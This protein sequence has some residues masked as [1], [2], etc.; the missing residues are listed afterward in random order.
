MK[1]H[2]WTV[3]VTYKSNGA[4]THTQIDPKIMMMMIKR[5]RRFWRAYSFRYYITVAHIHI[6]QRIYILQPKLIQRIH[7]AK[8]IFPSLLRCPEPIL[9]PLYLAVIALLPSLPNTIYKRLNSP[10][11]NKGPI[12]RYLP[13]VKRVMHSNRRHSLQ[14]IRSHKEMI[15]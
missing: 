13:G 6:A 7:Q 12:N 15:S 5:C 10:T 3:W 8:F 11:P 2:I 4:H 14:R 1:W 9:Y